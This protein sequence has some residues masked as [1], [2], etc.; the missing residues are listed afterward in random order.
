MAV[1]FFYI[2]PVLSP[3]GYLLRLRF[4]PTSLTTNPQSMGLYETN[5]KP[6]LVHKERTTLIALNQA[7]SVFCFI[8]YAVPQNDDVVISFMSFM[9]ICLPLVYR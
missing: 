7:V 2:G 9:C 4:P 5:L 1:L 8:Y 6:R 3:A